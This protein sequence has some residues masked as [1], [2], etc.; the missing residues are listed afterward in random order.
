[1][2]MILKIFFLIIGKM[3]NKI[4]SS[5]LF[6][7]I[8]FSNLLM[9]C[10]ESNAGSGTIHF[11]LEA[12]TSPS[13]GNCMDDSICENDMCQHNICNDQMLSDAYNIPHQAKH[14]VVL[15]ATEIIIHSFCVVNLPNNNQ[16]CFKVPPYHLPSHNR[17]TVL[18]I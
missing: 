10:P 11:V 9:L 8:V 1:M 4:I 18:R 6:A 7:M 13:C 14:V 5:Y 3:Q 15:P 12:C 17:Q 2:Q 16:T